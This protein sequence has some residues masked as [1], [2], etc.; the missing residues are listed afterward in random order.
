MLRAI[1]STTGKDVIIFDLEEYSEVID[2]VR[3]KSR[4][5]IIVCPECDQPVVV[6]AGT[7]KKNHFAHKSLGSCPL[8][9]ES[10]NVLLGRRILYTWLK[11]KLASKYPDNHTLLLEKTFPCEHLR[12]PIDCYLEIPKDRRFAYWILDSGVRASS[13]IERFFEQLQLPL[14]RIFL[15]H[16]LRLDEKKEILR[17]TPT[18]R[19]AI[20]WEEHTL[21]YLDIKTSKYTTFGG[22]K[23]YHSPQEYKFVYSITHDLSDM[24]FS[25]KTGALVHPDNDIVQSKFGK[26]VREEVEIQA[27]GE[28]GEQIEIEAKKGT[29]FKCGIKIAPNTPSQTFKSGKTLCRDCIS[30]KKNNYLQNL[31]GFN[32]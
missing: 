24:L 17:L 28:K 26:S 29:C 1:D 31:N 2:E 19:D 14:L 15:S 27:M 12:R 16:M 32:F 3:K 18:E 5:G 7:E 23:L 21:S 13:D 8:N 6:K 4:K 10:A 30:G 9:N 25:P 20:D 11:K 22:L